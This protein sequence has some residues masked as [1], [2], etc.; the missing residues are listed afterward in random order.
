MVDS[1]PEVVHI[2]E[3]N[4]AHADLEVIS[5]RNG[6][7]ALLKASTERPDVILLDAAL[8]DTEGFEICRQL[9][10]S[11]ETSHIPVIIVGAESQSKKRTA[12]I[13]GGADHYLTK[14]FDPKEVVALVKAYL[15][16]KERAENINPLTGLPNQLQVN[17]E[18]T[19]LIEQKKIF[20][21]IY[22]D[23]DDLRA[24]NKVYG[25]AQGDRAIRMV[26]EILGEAVR[27]FGNP[28]DLVGHLGGD[29]FVVI[30][31]TRKARILCRR[32]T[33]DYDSRIRSLYNREDLERGYIEYEGRLGQREQFPIMSLRAAVV[34]NE[35]RTLYHHLE[36]SESAAE[37]I[38]YLRRF[39][40]SNCYFDLRENGIEPELSLS[41]RGIP[42]AHRQELKILQG[43]LAWVDFLTMEID[44]PVTA[45]KDCLDWVE[46]VRVKNFT[47]Q[48][49]NSL[50]TIRENVSH[51][52]GVAEELTRL[53][54]GE[55]VTGGAVLE[56]VDLKSTL[57]WI[58]EQLQE[59]A[60]QQKIKVDIEKFEDIGRLMVDGR[61]LTQGL[62]YV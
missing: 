3:V 46:S 37:Q 61:I 56:E 53:A 34:T 35:R 8:P 43:V 33:A 25:F 49:W 62:L 45:I 40:G 15:K 19:G 30:T 13:V 41:H 2:L 48:Q 16:R 14:P 58:M 29:N 7:E 10:E 4:L 6:A 23:I 12:K 20:A 60:E 38:D 11:Q 44:I 21:A 42:H 57:D 17:N 50:K 24:F 28:D 18:I 31:T 1:D 9:R 36:V 59:L 22:V 52:L 51:L 47:P 5:A 55:W 39:P 27:L 26:A 32:I 54:R